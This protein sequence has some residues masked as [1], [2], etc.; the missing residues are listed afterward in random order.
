[1][2]RPVDD[3]TSRRAADT[4][5]AWLIVG[6]SGLLT[7]L[8][9]SALIVWGA[10]QASGWAKEQ[11]RA[12]DARRNAERLSLPVVVPPTLPDTARP[13]GRV[14]GWLG[15]DDYPSGARRRGEE[16]RVRVTLAIDR[17]G[18]PTGCSVARSSGSD[19]LDNGTC[20]VLMRNGRFDAAP[21]GPMV[22]R[23]TS[24]S[25]RWVLPR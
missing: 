20:L 11:A 19:S 25:I 14:A 21:G 8:L 23:W 9:L 2:V 3:F 10:R 13:V 22:R 4:R 17:D 24:P 1:M 18:R 15:P 7:L 12:A 16:G 6:F 5:L